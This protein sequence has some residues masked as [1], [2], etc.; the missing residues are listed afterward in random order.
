VRVVCLPGDGIGPE[1]MAA[2]ARVL[3][4][5][6]PE[7]ELEEHVIGG[8]AIHATGDPLPTETLAACRAA[9]AVLFGAVGLPEFDGKPVRPEQGLLQ[10]RRELDVYANLRP[11]RQGQID[12]LVVRELIGGLYFGA[13][14]RRD[15]GTA[16]DT[17][18]YHPTQIERITRRGFELARTRRHQVT[19]VDKANVLET[20]RLWREVVE[21]VR[22]DYSDVELR[23]MLVDNAAMQIVLAPDGF[24]VILTENMF[25]DILSDEAAA[26]TGGLGVAASAS[27]GD[28]GPG[29]FE[30]VHGSAPD[31]AGRGIANPAAMLRSVALMLTYGLSEPEFGAALDAAVDGALG[32]TPPP[33]LGGRATTEEFTDAVLSELGVD[34]ASRRP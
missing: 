16:F 14:G 27:V 9:D 3:H 2:A 31:I 26:L 4:V 18:E 29:I 7:L 21:R 13:R 17:C 10:L 19:S 22:P 15:D 6:L 28:G 8:A 5:L 12:L 20:S 23:H 24:D 25:G 1:V 32:T 11:A 30:P 33:D 34:A